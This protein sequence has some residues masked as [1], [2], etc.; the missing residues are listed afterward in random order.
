MSARLSLSLSLLLALAACGPA[1][2]SSPAGSPAP[3]SSPTPIP[4]ALPSPTPSATPT[5][6]PTPTATPTPQPTPSATPTPQPTPTATPTPVPTASSTP[7]ATL[8]VRVFDDLGEIRP[9]ATVQISS[10]DPNLALEETLREEAGSFRRETLP[11]NRVFRV[12]ATEGGMTSRSQTISLTPGEDRLLEFKDDFAIS[13][14]PEVV[15]IEPGYG[16][17][18]DPYATIRITFSESMDQ[19]SVENSIAI[20]AASDNSYFKA[21]NLAVPYAESFISNP[22][23]IVFDIGQFIP[24]WENSNRV[25]VLEPRISLPA[26]TRNDFR[27]VFNHQPSPGQGGAIRDRGGVAARTPQPK[28]TVIDEQDREVTVQ[29]GP[30]HIQGEH[31]PYIPFSVGSGFKATLGVAAVSGNASNPGGDYLRIY[32]NEPLFLSLPSGL[33]LPPDNTETGALSPNSYQITCDGTPLLM[34]PSAQVAYL[35]SDAVELRVVPS[36]SLFEV[37]ASCRVNISGII[38]PTGE[39]IEPISRSFRPL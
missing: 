20:Q 18:W 26:T 32:F 15:A 24:H 21:G 30:V 10:Q 17:V 12:T 5:P 1:P 33:N 38:T 28:Q 27:L 31:E 7:I 35:G 36:E 2:L 4:S 39:R 3:G 29:D 9:N 37:G 19:D 16:R 34:P 13:D 14:K 22:D 23:T 25:L 8:R 6:Q 11:A